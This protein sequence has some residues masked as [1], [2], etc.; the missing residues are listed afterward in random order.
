MQVFIDLIPTMIIVLLIAIVVV[1][2]IGVVGMGLG[3]KITPKVRN[4]LMKARVILQS[5]VLVLVI[6]M[7]TAA[8]LNK[9][10]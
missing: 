10:S 2:I 9:G 1:L 4:H 8:W 7:M 5:L 3:G 6:I